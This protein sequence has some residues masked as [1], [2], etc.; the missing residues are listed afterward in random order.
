MIQEKSTPSRAQIRREL[1]VL[2]KSNLDQVWIR[3]I[4]TYTGTFN[5]VGLAH[6]YDN[7]EKAKEV[8]PAH[9]IERNI[10][11]E[12]IPETEEETSKEAEEENA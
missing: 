11:V 6:I 10:K 7:P 4:K 5:T 9:I 1:A 8:E 2:M 12:T 3:N